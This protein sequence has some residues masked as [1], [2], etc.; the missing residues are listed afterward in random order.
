MIIFIFHVGT[1]FCFWLHRFWNIKCRIFFQFWWF[2][3]I[4]ISFINMI[5]QVLCVQMFISLIIA[6]TYFSLCVCVSFNQCLCWILSIFP[7]SHVG[8]Y[9]DVSTNITLFYL[10]PFKPCNTQMP[11]PFI[12]KPNQ[13]R[14]LT[15]SSKSLFSIWHQ[16]P[17]LPSISAFWKHE[18]A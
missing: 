5:V 15:S 7:I 6:N 1:R 4:F 9:E 16:L 12:G 10:Y 18:Q 3:L 11:I 17:K 13:T 2:S 8:I 14:K